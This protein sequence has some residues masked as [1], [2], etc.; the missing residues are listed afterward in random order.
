MEIQ[1]REGDPATAKHEYYR[2]PDTRAKAEGVSQSE[3]F[4]AGY[5]NEQNSE[6]LLQCSP[7]IPIRKKHNPK[8][9]NSGKHSN[10]EVLYEGSES[11]LPNSQI[12]KKKKNKKPPQQNNTRLLFWAIFNYY[13]FGVVTQN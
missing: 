1:A 6:Q 13:F 2:D 11:E 9:T 8:P 7:F 4:L 3:E 10:P 5:E 12:K